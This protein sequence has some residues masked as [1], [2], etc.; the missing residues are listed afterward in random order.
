MSAYSVIGP[1]ESFDVIISNPPYSLDL[2][3]GGNSAVTDRGDLGFSIIRG[4][5]THLKPSGAA[6]LLYGSIFYHEVIAKL[7]RYEGYAVSNES[8]QTLTP[9]EVETL[10]NF[11][12][13]RL[14]RAQGLPADAFY[15]DRDRDALPWLAPLNSTWLF[16]VDGVRPVLGTLPDKPVR[17]PGMIVIRHD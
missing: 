14:L 17:H 3:A 5:D 16:P 8:P 9:L 12:L 15:F 1:D 10:F 4:L 2:D 7:A 13:S 11:Y 6:V